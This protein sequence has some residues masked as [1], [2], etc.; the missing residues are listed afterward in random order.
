MARNR[1]VVAVMALWLLVQIGIASGARAEEPHLGADIA[2]GAISA[3]A[4]VFAFPVRVAACVAT[5]ALGGV[6]YGLTF[7]TSELLR[8]EIVAGTNYTC[9]G[10]FYF[11][12][13]EVKQFA[14]EPEQRM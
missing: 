11:T 9:G 12:P 6:T 7:G 8:Q 3:L 14:K 10:R 4:T 2:A 5:V 13:E 1:I